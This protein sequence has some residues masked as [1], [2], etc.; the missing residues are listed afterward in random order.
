[1]RQ[2]L[3]CLEQAPK[4]CVYFTRF[5]KRFGLNNSICTDYVS[6]LVFFIRSITLL[7]LTAPN[8]TVV[9]I[10]NKARNFSYPL[11][12]SFKERAVLHAGHAWV[13]LA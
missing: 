2:S 8:I 6:A 12:L 5:G 9:T 7:I 13:C 10:C 11:P 4:L 3:A 1:M